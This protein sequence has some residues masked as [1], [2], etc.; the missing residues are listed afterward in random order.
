M[1][2]KIKHFN[3]PL[4]VELVS[5]LKRFGNTEDLY[6]CAIEK[7]LAKNSLHSLVYRKGILRSYHSSALTDLIRKAHKR[8]EDNY[9]ENQE[10]KE[11]FK[12][13]L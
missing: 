12:T 9:A 3:K 5:Y 4:D 2:I 10:V 7:G 11:K 8:I 13:Y 6:G 1:A